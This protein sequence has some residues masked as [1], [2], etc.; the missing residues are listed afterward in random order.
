M[1]A[2]HELRLAINS[3]SLRTKQ[4]RRHRLAD[5]TIPTLAFVFF[6]LATP[7]A[8]GSL[9]ARDQI[10]AAAVTYATGAAMPDP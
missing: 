9:Q 8:S 7:R 2:C 4:L 3:A 10:G 5:V 6:F 1:V